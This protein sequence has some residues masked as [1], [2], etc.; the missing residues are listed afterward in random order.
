MKEDDSK[1]RR[2]ISEQL[3]EKIKKK[4]YTQH[5]DGK[6]YIYSLLKKKNKSFFLTN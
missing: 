5:I 4:P 3:K 6:Q 2:F 1:R